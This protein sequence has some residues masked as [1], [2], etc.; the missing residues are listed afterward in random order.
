MKKIL[1]LSLLL[2][3]V[4]AAFIFLPAKA[5]EGAAGSAVNLK[6][7]VRQ[8]LLERIPSPEAIKDYRVIKKEGNA[9]WGIRNEVKI[10]SSTLEAVAIKVSDGSAFEKIISPEFIRLY[11][12]VTKIGA[13]LWGVRKETPEKTT[14]ISPELSACASSAIDKKD[15]AVK[16]IV[17]SSTT[18]L[19]AAIDARNACQKKAIIATST[20]AISLRAC[21]E[22]FQATGKEIAILAKTAQQATWNAYQ[23]DL[24]ACR[25]ASATGTKLMIEDGGLS[26]ET[27]FGGR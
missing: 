22:T 27:I 1:S 21:I 5:E 3:I 15:A 8:D 7:Q 14:I 17:A 2:L 25:P 16:G 9:L 4:F 13:S 6:L 19:S 18:A 11:N 26:F 23:A 24:Q 10:S 20:Q 12:K